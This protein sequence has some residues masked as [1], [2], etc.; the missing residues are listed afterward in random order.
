MNSKPVYH[1]ATLMA[2]GALC[3]LQ[4][5][6][7]TPLGAVPEKKG[8]ANPFFAMDT[9]T[10]DEKH[11]TAASQAA[12]LK[13]LGYAGLGCDVNAA[14]PEML[15]ALDDNGL[16]LFAVYVSAS[17]DPDKP[18]YDP[19][20]KE[21]VRTLKGRDTIVWLVIRG[22]KSSSTDSDQ[23]AV[24]IVRE[25]ADLAAAAGLRVSLYPHT[26]DYVARVED[27]VRIARKVDRK[28]VGVTF[29]LCHWLRLDDAKNMKPLLK[30]AMPHLSVVTINGADSDGKDWTTLIQTLDR[31]TFDMYGFLKTLKD[32]GF[33]GP[34]GLQHYGIKGD[35]HENLKRSMDAWRKLSARL[36]AEEK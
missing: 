32:M 11:Q 19:R 18:K 3:F 25:L 28:N 30:L 1:C 2:V 5:I 34:I 36:A 17:V 35:A 14:G 13:E 23:R 24:E 21:V 4:V 22:G 16:K 7:R 27:A 26:G 15:R 33:T 9:G 6:S 29:N 10:K 20:L 31:G 8:L 12:M